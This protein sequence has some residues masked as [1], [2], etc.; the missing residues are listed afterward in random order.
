MRYR[1]FGRTELSMPVFSCGGMRYQQSWKDVDWPEITPESQNNLEATLARSLELGIN[2]IE[3]ARYYGSSERQLGKALAAY[4]RSAIILQT[5]VP[6]SADPAE[7]LETFDRSMSLLQ[8]DY[9]DLLSI[10]GVN[11]A[12]LLAWTLRK[13]GCLDLAERLQAEGRARHIGFSTHAPLPVILEAI[14]SDRFSYI[15][16]HWYYIF[17][18]NQA[19]LEAAQ[20]HDMGVFIISPSD[21][22][23]HL[24][25][26]PQKLVD[27]CQPLHPMVF[28]DLFC[29]SQPQIHTLSIGAAR[30]SD[31]D[32]HLETL[33][34][35]DQAETI[36]AP[37]LRRLEQAMAD[38]LGHDWLDT[39]RDGLP[40]PE[41]TPGEINIPTIVW[42][43]NL[44]QAFDMV[45]YAKA[46][47]NLLGNGGHW[48]PG[49]R[50]GRF[51]RG[52][53]ATVLNQSP[54]RDRILNILQEMDSLLGGTAVARLS[55]S[56]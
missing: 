43:H 55:Q 49:Q 8:T 14:A 11:N 52:T 32:R 21:K 54:H 35:L 20:E 56:D 5:K 25:S 53:L 12:E 3:T 46:R 47:Y 17:Q 13:G 16:L 33:P 38:A 42:L 18:T 23:G 45:E 6:P 7:F 28:N 1:R 10:H 19:A 4:P 26:P 30:P 37:I 27:L 48:F 44:V 39:W 31:F 22:G 2:H 40:A 36:L 34:L 9:V 29:L 15:N 41:T 24:Y 51:D 50:A